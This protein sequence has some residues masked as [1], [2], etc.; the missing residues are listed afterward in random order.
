[1]RRDV[2]RPRPDID[3]AGDAAN[4]LEPLAGSAASTLFSVGLLGAGLLAAAVVPLATAYS[5]CEAVG[6]EAR[7]DDDWRTAP[8]FHRAYVATIG[9]A[10]I[11]VAIPGLPLLT[12]LV[13]SQTLTRCSCAR[14]SCSCGGWRAIAR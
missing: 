10:A 8:L 7:L 4:A 14:S 2:A 6:A 5:V 13:G 3:D 11:I 12:V 1:M 9:V